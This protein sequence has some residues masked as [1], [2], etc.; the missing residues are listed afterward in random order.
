MGVEMVAANKTRDR[1]EDF[2]G[3]VLHGNHIDCATQVRKYSR[4]IIL[5]LQSG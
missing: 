3:E 1:M 4:E 2:D 5:S